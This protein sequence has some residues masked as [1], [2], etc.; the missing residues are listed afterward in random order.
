[1]PSSP[2]QEQETNHNVGTSGDPHLSQELQV[3]TRFSMSG[4]GGRG[5]GGRG[6]SGRGGRGRGGRGCHYSSGRTT[7][8]RGLCAAPSKNVF[9]HGHKGAANKM[10][11]SWEKL[12][13]CVRTNCGQD[14]SN[15]LQNKT[16]VTITEPAYAPEALRK[17]AQ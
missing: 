12:V 5:R 1:M 3:P 2:H 6:N 8:K 15:E 7:V 17:H 4:R 14:I 16:T 9:D 13:Q 11:T 10:R